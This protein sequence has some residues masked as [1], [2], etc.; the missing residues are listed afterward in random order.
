MN[1]RS[2]LCIL[3]FLCCITS[4]S[5]S[6]DINPNLPDFASSTA[7]NL[8]TFVKKEIDLGVNPNSFLHRLTQVRN[9]DVVKD[10]LSTL[11]RYGANPN[12][13]QSPLHQAAQENNLEMVQELLKA[14]SR[15]EVRDSNNWTP[16]HIATEKGCILVVQ[17]LLAAG[18]NPNAIGIPRNEFLL[19]VSNHTGPSDP[20]ITHVQ[21]YT[22][23][24]CAATMRRNRYKIAKA[25]LDAG[26]NPHAICEIGRKFRNQNPKPLKLLDVAITHG[27]TETT[28][29]IR[30]A[31][32][33]KK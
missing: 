27:N 29:L 26:A 4:I 20:T 3:M 6:M 18:A 23:L 2:N 33:N 25:L 17:H 28:D 14:G 9:T 12:Y 11:F 21:G 13:S 22:P 24:F 1:N 19:G 16:L 32:Q 31:Q 10:A 30:R 5:H 7:E 15:T 8:A